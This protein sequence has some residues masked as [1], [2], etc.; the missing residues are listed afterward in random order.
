MVTVNMVTVNEADLVYAPGSSRLA[1][2]KQHPLVQ[3]IL[4]DSFDILRCSLLSITAFPDGDL[5]IR[6]IRDALLRS[7]KHH[8]P[9]ART[10]HQRLLEDPVYFR[11][12]ARLVSLMNVL[13]HSS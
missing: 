12:I 11:R 7:A 6:F 9:G 4:Q 10:I 5:T 2:N 13:C 8:N 1:L 3:I